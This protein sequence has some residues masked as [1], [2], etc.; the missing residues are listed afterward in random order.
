[1][2]GSDLKGL[3]YEPLFDYLKERQS[4]FD[5]CSAAPVLL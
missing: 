3:K 4:A 2:K 5:F 1:M